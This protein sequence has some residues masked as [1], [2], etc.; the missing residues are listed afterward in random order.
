MLVVGQALSTED[1]EETISS[2]HVELRD[3]LNEISA[4]RSQCCTRIGKSL[5]IYGPRTSYFPIQCFWGVDW[6][7]SIATYAFVIVPTVWWLNN[8]TN[9][10]VV[11]G[12]LCTFI[13]TLLAYSLTACSDPGIVFRDIGVNDLDSVPEADK[14]EGTEKCNKCKIWRPSTASH[15]YECD[16]C[17]DKLDHHCPWTGKCIGKRTMGFFQAFL[18]GL[19]AHLVFLAVSSM[20]VG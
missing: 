20:I 5:L 7:C 2:T 15:C 10:W 12:G 8:Q 11:T 13:F 3:D 1:S 4:S 19:V 18:F 14:P 6:K 16:A 17:I 9:P